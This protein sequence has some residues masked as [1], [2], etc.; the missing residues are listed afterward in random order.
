MNL[1]VSK[2]RTEEKNGK[3]FT[4]NTYV[5]CGGSGRDSEETVLP[6]CPFCFLQ[7]TTNNF[8][9]WSIDVQTNRTC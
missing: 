2:L 1:Y 8:G 7:K 5:V 6:P 9:K 4:K 3:T